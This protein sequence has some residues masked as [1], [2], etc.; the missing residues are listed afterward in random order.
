MT[1]VHKRHFVSTLGGYLAALAVLASPI[2]MAQQPTYSFRDSIFSTAPSPDDLLGARAG[3][4]SPYTNAALP[5]AFIGAAQQ[6]GAVAAFSALT[7]DSSVSQ[8]WD[9]LGPIVGNVSGPWTYTGRPTVVS[10]RITALAIAPSCAPGACTLF[11]AAAGGGVWRTNDALARTPQWTSVSQGLPTDAVGSI[12][13]DPTDRSHRTLYVG[14]GETN[15]SSDSEAGLGL[16]KS[17]DLGESWDLVPGSYAVSVGRAIGAVAVDPANASH[18]LIGTG[19]ARHGMSSTYGGRYTPPNSPQIGLYESHDGGQ[20]FTL[21]F[22]QPS[23]PVVPGTANGLD[24]FRGG[25]TKIEAYQRGDDDNEHHSATQFYF[26]MMDY[27]LFRSTSAGGYELVFAS[28]G[29]GTVAGSANARTEF[30]LV[31]M[32][33]GLRIYLGDADANG[34]ANLYRTDNANVAASK[35]TGSSGNTG[36]IQLSNSTTGTLGFGSYRFCRTQCSYD[37]FVASPRGRPNTVWIGGAMQYDDI[38]VFPNLSNGRAVMRSTNKGVS[39]TDMTNDTLGPVPNGMHPDQHAIVFAPGQPDVAFVGSDGGLVRT[40]GNFADTSQTCGPTGRKLTG[41]DL[42]NCQLWLSVIPNEIIVLN[43]GL[44]TLQ[45]QGIALDPH[46]PRGSLIGGTQDNGS[47]AWDGTNWLE[48]VGGD[49]GQAAISTAGNRMHTYT[50]TTG[51]INFRGNDPLG[52]NIFDVPSFQNPSNEAAAFY[53]PLIADLRVAGTWFIGQQHVWRTTDDLGGQAYM[54]LHCNEFTADLAQP[55]G[56][57]QALGGPGGAGNAGDLVSGQYGTDKGGSWVALIAQGDPAAYRAA[58]SSPLWVGTRRGRVFVSMN[59]NA[60]D[61]TTVVFNRIDTAK[62]PARFVSGISVDPR[63]PT[64]A[65][66]SFSGY[67]AYTP[68]T[69]GHVFEV[70]YHPESGT[71][72]WDDLSANL[73]D[74]PILGVAYDPQTG[75]LYAATDYGVVVRSGEGGTWHVAGSALPPV[76]VYQLVIDSASRSLYAVTH[77]RGIYRLDL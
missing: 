8:A 72:S 57:W 33:D 11:V 50:G 47:W 66:V 75:R 69:P 40:D 34:V 35:L 5:N 45:Y 30:D 9:L 2:A 26:S 77:G 20:T 60:A 3:V 27:G 46:N 19:V 63:H 32:E 41:T 6:R 55:C 17:T 43:A 13:F 12:I 58:Q 64:T 31:P 25:V 74:Q 10:G 4:E 21:A 54:E 65:F 28:A 49:G 61:P 67:N 16:F 51:D 38:F 23:D 24:F 76:A 52:W 14:T 22:S 42:I 39:F 68:A 15:G 59:A 1:C 70:H 62:Q 7:A 73:G 37:M 56:D 48:T 53:S 18:I 71:A 29:G 44:A 36:W